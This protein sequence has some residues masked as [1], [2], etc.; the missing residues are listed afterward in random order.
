MRQ[1]SVS[2]YGPDG[3]QLPVDTPVAA[4]L[5]NDDIGARVYWNGAVEE[6]GRL[7]FHLPYCAGTGGANLEVI[8]PGC[9]PYYGRGLMDGEWPEAIELKEGTNPFA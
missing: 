8:I 5:Y 1:V 2:I 4:R 9:A 6:T 7:L 3:H